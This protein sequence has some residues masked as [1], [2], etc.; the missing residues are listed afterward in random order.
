M[1]A[2]TPRGTET[3]LTWSPL[4]RVWEARVRPTGS[5]RAATARTPAAMSAIRPWVR[6]RRSCIT[7]EMVSWAAARSR[8]LARQNGGG[9]RLQGVGHGQK[10]GFLL[11]GGEGGQG[12]LGRQRLL[13]QGAGDGQLGGV[14]SGRGGKFVAAE[15][16]RR[17]AG[18]LAGG[19]GKIHGSLILSFRGSG[20]P[21]GL[22]SAMS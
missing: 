6:R 9:V 14:G 17:I 10:N 4:G 5:G 18:H 20:C 11:L 13:Q 3:L 2:M 15:S 21:T 16:G 7:G 19:R 22:P 12:G 8:A 1:M